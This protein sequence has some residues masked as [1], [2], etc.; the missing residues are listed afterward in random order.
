MKQNAQEVR[1]HEVSI[2]GQW[3]KR[4]P[5]QASTVTPRRS[6]GRSPEQVKDQRPVSFREVERPPNNYITRPRG[7]KKSQ[8]YIYTNTERTLPTKNCWKA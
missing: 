3:K 2:F 5:G 8:S 7:P 1:C 4:D 6:P